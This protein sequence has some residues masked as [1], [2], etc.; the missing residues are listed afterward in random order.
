VLFITHDFGVV[1]EIADRVAVMQRGRI[2]EVDT[3]AAVLRHP[4]H[5]YTQM[6]IGAVP[7]MRPP[8]QRTSRPGPT[9]LA[10]RGVSKT[11]TPTSLFGW[12][13]PVVALKDADLEVR[14]GEVFGVVG[15]SGSGKSTLARCVVRLIDPTGG[16]I[17]LGDREIAGAYGEGLR[18]E[19]RRVQIIFQDPYRSLNPRRTVGQS[20]VEC[21]LNF[22]VSEDEA[23]ERA[24]ELIRFV[25][26]DQK[27][28]Q[29]Y[30]HEFSGGQ[31]QR[32]CIARALSVQPE[33][34]IADEAVS[35]L[36]VSVQAQVLRLLD[37]V[38]KRFD[39]AILFITHDLRV[40]AQLCDRVAVMQRGCIVEEGKTVEVFNRPRDPYTRQL[41]ESAPGREWEFGAAP[42]GAP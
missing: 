8:E 38:R 17:R 18:R 5:P 10:L 13:E 36:D 31:R 19:R 26:L 27:V 7:S 14:R 37:D 25:G 39:L 24:R 15:E 16:S 41:L 35:A 34:L 30:P 3:T 1:A 32:V 42:A 4:K 22:G 9:A 6:L 2:V 20:I 29:R 12:R 28:L 11:Y 33:L 21:P 23:W 40:A